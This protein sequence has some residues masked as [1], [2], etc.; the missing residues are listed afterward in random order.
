ML[1]HP[2]TTSGAEKFRQDWQSRPEFGEWLQALTE[3]RLQ[4]IDG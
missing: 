3:K 2:L 4:A 1:D